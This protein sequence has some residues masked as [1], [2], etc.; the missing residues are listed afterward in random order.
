LGFLF[1]C[2]VLVSGAVRGSSL[3]LF[4]VP[5]IEFMRELP[6]AI[7]YGGKLDLAMAVWG[8]FR[9]VLVVLY[10]SFLSFRSSRNAVRN[11]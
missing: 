6:T 9:V 8:L 10:Y 1:L 3:I 2:L 7:T 5:S 4:A 11:E